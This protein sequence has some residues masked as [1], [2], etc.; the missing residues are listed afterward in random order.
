M[1]LTVVLALLI[2]TIVLAC[3][4][5]APAPTPFPTTTAIPEPTSLPT[6][7]PL[8]EPTSVATSTPVPKPTLTP[9]PN[10]LML[11]VRAAAKLRE[12]ERRLE[13]EA[14]DWLDQ[15]VSS[16]RS[17]LYEDAITNFD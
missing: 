4:S 5:A 8:P 13:E 10:A 6:A 12:E 3:S 2:G 7:T 17:G 9:T 14:S 15:G 16:Y 11:E 1:K